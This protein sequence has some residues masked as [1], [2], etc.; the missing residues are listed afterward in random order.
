MTKQFRGY[1]ITML[2]NWLNYI[3]CQ[4]TGSRRNNIHIRSITPISNQIL[5]STFA[6]IDNS[7]SSLNVASSNFHC[8]TICCFVIISSNDNCPRTCKIWFDNIMTRI[9]VCSKIGLNM[10]I[11]IKI[12][13]CDAIVH[14]SA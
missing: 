11:L 3:I 9:I 10:S 6:Q 7:I 12:I 2:N 13:S 1:C 4:F 5:S 14:T 8:I